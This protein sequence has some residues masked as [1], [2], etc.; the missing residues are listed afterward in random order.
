VPKESAQS[1]NALSDMPP[2]STFRS[3][4][5][6]SSILPMSYLIGTV[7]AAVYQLTSP[8]ARA[9]VNPTYFIRCFTAAS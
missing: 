4:T 8:S 3:F 5:R 2:R 6:K 7:G 1:L 9:R